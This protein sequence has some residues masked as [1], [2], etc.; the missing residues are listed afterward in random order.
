MCLNNG[1]YIS[2]YIRCIIATEYP[3]RMAKFNGDI[4]WKQVSVIT[5]KYAREF[6]GL[7][8]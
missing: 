6:K 1:L 8:F 7:H 4:M 5:K 2:N 3:Y